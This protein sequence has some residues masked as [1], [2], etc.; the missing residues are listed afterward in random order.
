M[1]GVAVALGILAW[2]LPYRWNPFRFK[3]FIA[4][5]LSDET[6]Q[7]VPKVISVILCILG[8][9]ILIGTLVVGEFE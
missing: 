7:K 3:R 4:S 2:I 8:I 1:G 6:N 5:K 9:A